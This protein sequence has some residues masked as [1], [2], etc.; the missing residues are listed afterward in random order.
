MALNHFDFAKLSSSSTPVEPSTALILFI[1]THPWD[2]SN[3]A[4]LDYIERWNLVWKLYSTK[5]GKL[6]N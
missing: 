6:A 3:E 1:S 2:S 4:L 5:L